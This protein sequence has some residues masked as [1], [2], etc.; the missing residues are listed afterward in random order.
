MSSPAPLS[1]VT[2]GAPV[3]LLALDQVVPSPDNPRRIPANDPK[4]RELADSL[5]SLG[6]LMPIVVRQVVDGPA[7]AA[8]P[9][10]ILAGERRYRAAVLAKLE[11]IEA[12]VVTCDDRTALEIIVVENL[13][14]EGLHPLEEARG[15]RRLI[16]GGWSLAEIAAHL[17]KS[18]SWVALRAQL[19]ALSKTWWEGIAAGKYEWAKMAHLEQLARLPVEIQDELAKAY[20]EDWNEGPSAKDLAKEIAERF[21]HLLKTAPWS[22][23]DAEL[24]PQVGACAR[25]PKRSSC[26]QDLFADVGAKDRCLDVTCWNG[27]VA[28]HTRA[29]AAKLSETHDKVVILTE[30]SHRQESAPA[31]PSDLPATAVQV[32]RYETKEVSKGTPGALPAINPQTGRQTW[33]K[34][35]EYASQ[36]AKRTLGL[37]IPAPKPGGKGSKETGGSAKAAAALRQAKR[38][39]MRLLAIG[40]AKAKCSMP[41]QSLLLRLLVLLVLDN[42]LDRSAATW[43]LAASPKRTLQDDL[44][45][46]WEH[47]RRQLPGTYEN[48][49]STQLPDLEAVQA[50]ERLV[51][52]DPEQQ[53]EKALAEVPEP[54]ARK[55]KA[56]AA[57]PPMKRL[58]QA[59]AAIKAASPAKAKVKAKA[60]KAKR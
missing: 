16:D 14:R 18:A 47:V 36:E 34:P 50:M 1:S 20:E 49:Y 2:T 17:G 33:V 35:S 31:I 5:R 48:V 26:Q 9:F 44:D 23:D 51:G 46:M 56:A 29:Q 32:L 59:K 3:R 45:V 24:V 21:L 55:A 43:E 19:T 13:Q 42:G 6:Q 38:F 4:V 8:A 28:A 60:G 22:M 12:K 53:G 11:A 30:T 25:C 54:E 15:V 57:D 39:K 7:G 58:A 37:K 27:K 10:V 40:K 52:L 41:D